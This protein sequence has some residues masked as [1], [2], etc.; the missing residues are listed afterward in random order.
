MT[1]GNSNSNSNS[2]GNSNRNSNSNDV[3]LQE[4]INNANKTHW[5]IQNILDIKHI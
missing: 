4:R 1:A 3:D 5:I 2:N